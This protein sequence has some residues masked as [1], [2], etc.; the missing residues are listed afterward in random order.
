MVVVGT[1][2]ADEVITETISLNG[3]TLVQGNKA[4]KT[5]TKVTLPNLDSPDDAARVGWGDKIGLPYKLPHNTVLHAHLNNVRE[6]SVTVVT[7]STAVESNTIDLNSALNGND[8]D[9]YLVV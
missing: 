7:S 3:S 6:S 8:V 4:F 1:N 5:V 2:V 9:V